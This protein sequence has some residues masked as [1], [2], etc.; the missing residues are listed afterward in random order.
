MPNRRSVTIAAGAGFTSIPSIGPYHR[1][2]MKE[3]S[4]LQI[5]VQ[6]AIDAFATTNSSDANLGNT[7]EIV[8]H[9]LHGFIAR[10]AGYNAVGSPAA[11]EDIARVRTTAGAGGTLIV[12]EFES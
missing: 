11:A 12:E 4:G 9:G 5:D 8:G 3:T 7:V 10:P 6:S 2:R 1:V